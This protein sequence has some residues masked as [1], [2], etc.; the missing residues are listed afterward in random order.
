MALKQLVRCNTKIF[1]P[2]TSLFGQNAHFCSAP[3]DVKRGLVLG[4]YNHDD[5][6]IFTPAAEKFN[7][8]LG[9]K[10]MDL[11]KE[12][13]PE[14]RKGNA[15]I[16]NNIEQDFW[17]IAV[18]GLGEQKVGLNEVECLDED[19]E[20]VRVAAAVGAKMLAK[21]GCHCIC[22]DGMDFPEQAAEG[23][24]LAVWRYQTNKN[25]QNQVIVPNLE[26]FD[27][28]DQDSWQRGL[29]KAESQNLVRKLCDTP[30]N[31]MTPMLFA[32]HTVNELCPSGIKVDVHDINWIVAKK[33]DLFLTVA[34]G[35][36]VPPLLI[37]MNYCGAPSDQKPVLLVGKGITFDAGGLCLKSGRHISRHRADMAGAAVVV[38]AIRAASAL[39]LPINITGI[40]PLCENMPSS[41]AMKVGDVVMGMNGK[42]IKIEDVDNEGRLCLADAIVY[43][44]EMY[45]PRLVIDVTT[46]TKG[47]TAALGSSATGVFSN[48]HTMWKEMMKAGSVTGDRMWRMP[49]WKCYTKNV[50]RKESVDLVNKGVGP[51]D[52]C[53]AAAFIKEFIN[54]VDWIH[55]DINGVGMLCHDKVYPYLKRGRMSGRP[56][57]TLI[58]FLHQI[59]CPSEPVK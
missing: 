30:A 56:T 45:K 48:S 29:F 34:R 39:S 25:K 14:V 9:G 49:L 53:L 35:S 15:R 50:T 26:L 5:E 38:A 1:E 19:L 21:Q 11:V 58:Q 16:F 42:S 10:L 52:A 32:E 59:A 28:P 27:H 37:E 41:M 17:S 36:C 46:E 22:L 23:S 43:G 40:V 13:G 57:R 54:C 4:V 7:E 18:V 8:R 55:L 6:L 47:I 33:M 31:Q 51:G 44:Q 12:A 3:E 20:N 2:V 24:A